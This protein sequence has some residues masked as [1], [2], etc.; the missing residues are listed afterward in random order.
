MIQRE[1]GPHCLSSACTEVFHCAVEGDSTTL[2][3]AGGA[4][5][6]A[7]DYAADSDGESPF[8]ETSQCRVIKGSPKKVW[9]DRMW[10][11]TKWLEACVE[12]LEEE[13]VPWWL[14]VPPLMDVGA[15]GARELAKCFLA[16]WQWMVEVAT[17]N[18]CPPAPTM[19]NIGHFLDEELKEGDHMP[20]LL[21]YACALQHMGEA[22]EG[23]M[24]H[25]IGMRFTPQ[26]FPLVDTFIK[27]TG[28]ELT[29]LGIASCRGQLAAEVLLQK[30]DGPFA[31][32]IAYLGDLAW[33]ML[34]QKVWDELVF[35]APLTGPSVPSKSN[36]L[37][38]ILGRTVD[39]GG[40][41]P[42]LR[43]H[44]TETSGKFVGVACGLLF[45]RNVLPYDPA[46]NGTE[47]VPVQGIVN[48]L[49]PRRGFICTGA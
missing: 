11:A 34:T 18:F 48:D 33:C 16:M 26:V 3:H 17:T 4:Q 6:M 1:E 36:H 43:F 15:P 13:D 20:W 27:D 38:Y 2:G 10:E 8:P 37:G 49:F 39:L 14:L 5:A 29:E 19:L 25:P 28:A 24:W 42:P 21:A 22:A 46:S 30:Q 45:E 12:T 23:R 9:L 44:V 7:L 47:W 40:T 35:P 31:D 32:V 41:L